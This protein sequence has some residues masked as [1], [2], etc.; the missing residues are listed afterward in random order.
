MRRIGGVYHIVEKHDPWPA[1]DVMARI[2]NVTDERY[3]EVFGFRSTGI[4]ALVA[5]QLR[6]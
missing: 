1:L 5:L 3:M 6:Y 4:N 2:N